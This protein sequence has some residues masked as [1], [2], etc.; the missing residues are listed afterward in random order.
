M[1]R[2]Q[3]GNPGGGRPKNARNK[4]NTRF[5]EDLLA[6]WQEH[7]PKAIELV[8]KEDPVAYVKVVAGT[9]PREFVVEATGPLHEL[10]DEELEAL[11]QHVRQT[12][13]RVINAERALIEAKD[14]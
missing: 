5:L 11:L 10:S 9:L 4:L 14:D 1:M 13:A 7:G 12:H 3:P 6:D 2:F 8:R